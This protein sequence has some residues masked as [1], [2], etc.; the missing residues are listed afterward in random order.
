MKPKPVDKENVLE[1]IRQLVR[2]RPH[3]TWMQSAQ[4]LTRLLHRVDS[5]RYVPP[6]IDERYPMEEEAEGDHICNDVTTTSCLTEKV[7]NTWVGSPN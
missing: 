1:K 4:H 6:K 2:D 3:R 5:T 7:T